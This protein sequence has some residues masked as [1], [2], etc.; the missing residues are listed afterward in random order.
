MSKFL[1]LDFEF[2]GSKEKAKV[3]KVNITD[4]DVI[5]VNLGDA[6]EIKFDAYP[7]KNFEGQVVEIASMADPYTNTYEVEIEVQEDGK[8]LL[9]GFIGRVNILTKSSEKLVEIPIDA[10]VSGHENRASVFIVEKG[11]AMKVEV[12]VYKIEKD[13]LL[14]SKG[15]NG[16]ENVVVKGAGALSVDRVVRC[17]PAARCQ[18]VAS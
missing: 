12:E 13:K 1:N 5:F 3:I 7:N 11:K 17:W 4:K 2:F 10:L 6:A 16:D 15:L 14:I 9:S 18:E 8:R